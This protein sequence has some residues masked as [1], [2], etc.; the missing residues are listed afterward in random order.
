MLDN[1]TASAPA[2]ASKRQ[3]PLRAIRA[4]CFLCSGDS[5]P[6]IKLCPST[7]CPLHAFRSGHRPT[8]ADRALAPEVRVHPHERPITRGEYLAK[9]TSRSAIKRRCIDCSGGSARAAKNCDRVKC[10]LWPL[11]P[12]QRIRTV[13]E[14]QRAAA[15]ARLKALRAETSPVRA[16][17]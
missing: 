2:E 4:H 14:A 3:S 12:G 7:G 17:G 5:Y 13:T 16:G 8:D 15:A 6:E 11:R 10:A 1:L 9:A